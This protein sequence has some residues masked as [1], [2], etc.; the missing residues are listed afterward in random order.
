M[1]FH[2]NAS[3]GLGQILFFYKADGKVKIC[4]RIYRVVEELFC[5]L[6]PLESGV[7]LVEQSEK[8]IFIDLNC[9]HRK[10]EFDS[11]DRR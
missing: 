4:L 6:C 1:Q 9:I 10:N 8:N 2:E 7:F 11:I 5:T 3:T